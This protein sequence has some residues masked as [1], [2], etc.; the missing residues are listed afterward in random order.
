MSISA[1]LSSF[2]WDDRKINLIDTPGEPSF[3]ADALAR[4]AWSRAPCSSST[5]SWAPR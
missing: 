4:C 1:S 3:M 2:R 5:A